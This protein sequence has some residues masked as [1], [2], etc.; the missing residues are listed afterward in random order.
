MRQLS[1]HRHRSRPLRAVG[2]VL[3]VV[4]GVAIIG[5]ASH[6]A[7]RFTCNTDPHVVQYGDT[8]WAIAEAKCDGNIQAVT[9]NLV[10]TYGS[11]IQLSEI[12]WL[13]E[14][15]DCLLVNRGGEVY[16]ECG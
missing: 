15:Q 11:T 12:I 8:L 10:D 1:A 6:N 4:A 5:A 13:P 7:S 16:D 3:A 2:W 9:D 14:N